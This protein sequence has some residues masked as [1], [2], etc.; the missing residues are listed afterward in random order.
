MSD[1]VETII[2]R[3][4][5]MGEQYDPEY[6]PTDYAVRI[7]AASHTLDL[8]GLASASDE[9]FAHDL[10]IILF[11]YDLREKV[12]TEGTVP[13]YALSQWAGQGPVP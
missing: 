6:D 2:E 13:R 12:Y 3:G 8:D 7:M 1:A 4:R 9:D 5:R 11:N 10:S